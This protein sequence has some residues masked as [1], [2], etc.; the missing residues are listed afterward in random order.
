MLRCSTS[1]S[2]FSFQFQFPWAIHSAA[3]VTQVRP[4]ESRDRRESSPGCWWQIGRSL[5]AHLEADSQSERFPS[6]SSVPS[7]STPPTESI[8]N[9]IKRSRIALNETPSHRCIQVTTTD[10]RKWPSK[11]EILIHI[12]YKPKNLKSP[13]FSFFLFFGQI[14]CRSY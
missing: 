2:W 11:P 9:Y 7:P 4:V 13:K 5:A 10:N 3:P 1:N 6:P 12:N 14:L 8:T